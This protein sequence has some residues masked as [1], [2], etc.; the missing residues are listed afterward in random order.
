MGP[1]HQGTVFAAAQAILDPVGIFVAADA[2]AVVKGT[3][4]EPAEEHVLMRQPAAVPT[5]LLLEQEIEH[6]V[7][8]GR[9]SAHGRG[10]R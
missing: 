5:L 8:L 9:T 6:E 3:A 4:A 7:P 2:D 1:G 10:A